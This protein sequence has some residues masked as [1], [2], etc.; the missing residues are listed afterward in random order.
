MK[1]NLFF[2]K[3]LKKLKAIIKENQQNL[4]I[5]K[6]IFSYSLNKLFKNVPSEQGKLSY[7]KHNNNHLTLLKKNRM[8]QKISQQQIKIDI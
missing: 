8:A 1:R 3:A 5:Q 6:E 4:M 7:P 2:Y